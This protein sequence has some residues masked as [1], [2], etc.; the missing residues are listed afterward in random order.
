MRRVR[1]CIRGESDSV[2]AGIDIIAVR[3]TKPVIPHSV[4]Q[5][6]EVRGPAAAG[7]KCAKQMEVQRTE[8][9]ISKERMKVVE[10]GCSHEVARG[11]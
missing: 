1:I 6:Y 11:C 9:L 3:V 5:N 10:Q 8:L 2:G 7:I 4:R